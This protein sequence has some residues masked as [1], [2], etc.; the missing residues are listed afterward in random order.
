MPMGSP[1]YMSPEQ[2]RASS[3]IDPRTDIWSLG[4]VLFELLTAHAPFEAPSITLLTAT[5]LEQVAP[6]LRSQRADAPAE[7]EAIIAK[8]LEKDPNR[9][10]QDV[11]ELAIALYP[12]A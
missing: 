2:I 5:I 1:V 4:C 10:F 11:G 7:L 12:C 8:C 3:D 9:R 6:L